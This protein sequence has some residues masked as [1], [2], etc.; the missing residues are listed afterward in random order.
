[1]QDFIDALNQ[2]KFSVTVNPLV[3][4]SLLR[5]CLLLIVLLVCGRLLRL[6]DEIA[7]SHLVQ[8]RLE[9]SV[10]LLHSRGDKVR[11]QVISVRQLPYIHLLLERFHVF[12][13]LVLFSRGKL[14]VILF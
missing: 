3:L 1:M 10:E 4:L 8:N 7:K 9:I 13:F 6:N 11:E 12:L 5:R 2:T 14:K